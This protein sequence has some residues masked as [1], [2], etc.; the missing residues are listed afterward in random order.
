MYSDL[1][2]LTSAW[3]AGSI[4]G[5][6]FLVLKHEL[7]MRTAAKKAAVALPAS[8]AVSVAAVKAPMTTAVKL[9]ISFGLAAAAGATAIYGVERNTQTAQAPPTSA[10]DTYGTPDD[11]PQTDHPTGRGNLHIQVSDPARP[12]RHRSPPPDTVS[13]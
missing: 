10:S 9:L 5:E 1:D 2:E 6:Q 7:A 3:K 11:G 4:D 8:A 12:I 13:N